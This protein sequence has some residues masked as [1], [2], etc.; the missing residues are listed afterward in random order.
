MNRAD[1][2]K[3]AVDGVQL[4]VSAKVPLLINNGFTMYQPQIGAKEPLTNADEW[5]ELSGM[6]RAAGGERVLTI[7]NFQLNDDT[8]ARR[9][10][11]KNKDKEAGDIAYYYLDD[12]SVVKVMEA[13]GSPARPRVVVAAPVPARHRRCRHLAHAS[14]RQSH[15]ARQYLLRF[16]RSHAAGRLR[17]QR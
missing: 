16:R 11:G 14:A 4:L 15:P 5:H 10:I 13:D 12:V 7:G 1:R 3:W 9:L 2:A 6:V 8:G 17:N